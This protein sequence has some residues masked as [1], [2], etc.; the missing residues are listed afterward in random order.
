MQGPK[1][2]KY[3]KMQKGRVGG[4]F[5]HG[6]QIHFGEFG[7][8]SLSTE[9]ITL[10]QIEAARRAISR[11]LKRSGKLWIRIFPDLPVTSKPAEVRM[12][13]GK[14][15]LEFWAC[16]IKAGTMLFEINDVSIELAKDALKAGANKLPLKTRF[17]SFNNNFNW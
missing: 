17:I 7:L 15:N 12:G 10:Q 11:R 9:R 14:G 16:R 4:I 6:N 13:K 5:V 2:I 8:Q 3:R 1:R